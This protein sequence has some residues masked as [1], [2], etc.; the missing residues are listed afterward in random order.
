MEKP[1]V[2]AGARHWVWVGVVLVVG[3]ILYLVL[4]SSS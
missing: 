3:A 4:I 1:S 2:T